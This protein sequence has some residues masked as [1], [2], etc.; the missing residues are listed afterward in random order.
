MTTK[1]SQCGSEYKRIASH[2]NQSFKCEHPGFSDYQ[3]QII[4]GLLM[5]DGNIDS[6]NGN[7]FLQCKVISPNYLKYIDEK[8]GIFGNGVSLTKTAEEAAKMNRERGF[9]PNAKSDNYHDLYTWRSM[10]HPELQEFADWYATGK[11][12]WPSDIELTP[13]VLKHWYCGDGHYHN[14]GRHNHIIISMSNEV[15]NTQKVDK[16]FKN[17]GLPSPSNYAISELDDGNNKKCN[18]EF[19]VDQSK[20]LWEYM[21]EPLPDFEYKWPKEYRNS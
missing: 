14:S 16:I 18:A 1:C 20:E 8:F 21:G 11:K 12:V 4:T 10:R 17:S 9:R 19:T 5:G 3:K 2:W 6:H 7:P 15:N 13:T